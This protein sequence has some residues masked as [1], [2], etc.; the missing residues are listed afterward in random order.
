MSLS[1]CIMSLGPSNGDALLLSFSACWLGIDLHFTKTLLPRPLGWRGAGKVLPTSLSPGLCLQDEVAHT[2]TESRV[3][4]NTRYPF[5]T[6]SGPR[7][8]AGPSL[9]ACHAWGLQ[10]HPFGQ[11]ARK[12]NPATVKH[13]LRTGQVAGARCGSDSLGCQLH[14]RWWVASGV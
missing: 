1:G 9:P 13:R 10:A 2:V 11:S 7:S 6:V 12:E 8:Q 3:L 14:H 5:L 4:Q